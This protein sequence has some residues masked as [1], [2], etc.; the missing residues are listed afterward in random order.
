VLSKAGRRV[1]VLFI[2][3]GVI[4]QVG[5]FSVGVVNG[6][7]TSQA[8]R[9]LDA[10]H[11]RLGV[12]VNAFNLEAQQC[13]IS[14]GLECLH[15]ADSRLAEAFDRFAADVAQ[16]S[17]PATLDASTLIADAHDCSDALHA[18]AVATTQPAYA[19]AAARYQDAANQFDQDYSDFATDVDYDS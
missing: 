7:R 15:D 12:S 3:L 9:D 6:L 2:V 16:I 17:F 4:F 19:D 5:S 14:G 11:D 18:M 10:S 1:V 8:Y 13:A